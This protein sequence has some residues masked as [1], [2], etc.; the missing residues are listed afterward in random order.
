M[1]EPTPILNGPYEEPERHYHTAH[2]SS[3]FVVRQVFFCGGPKGAFDQW[4]KGLDDMAKRQAKRSAEQTLK[5]EI[6]D[7][8]FD[9][10][11]GFESHPIL[12]RGE[13]QKIAVRIIGQFGEES[14]RVFTVSDG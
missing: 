6:D 13:H 2:D 5:V 10:L 7:R 9:W 4:K 8:A 1:P 3:N 14:T 11:Y 12:V